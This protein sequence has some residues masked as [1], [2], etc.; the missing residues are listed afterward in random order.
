MQREQSEQRPWGRNMRGSL[1]AEEQ[2]HVAVPE[3]AE[4]RTPDMRSEREGKG[5]DCEGPQGPLSPLGPCFC[6]EW[7]R[8]IAGFEQ[9]V[10]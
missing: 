5:A 9:G 6:S 7:M 10:M 2:G 8:A 4:G 3:E 1:L